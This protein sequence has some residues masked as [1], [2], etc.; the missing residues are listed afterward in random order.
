MQA[1]YSEKFG[2]TVYV[3][4]FKFRL[5]V[6]RLLRL[7]RSCCIALTVIYIG[8]A[9]GGLQ[10]MSTRLFSVSQFKQGLFYQELCSNAS[11]AAGPVSILKRETEMWPCWRN[12]RHWFHW[13]LLNKQ[14]PMK[15]VTALSQIGDIFVSNYIAPELDHQCAWKCTD[16]VHTANLSM[17]SSFPDSTAINDTVVFGCQMVSFKIFDEISR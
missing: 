16:T 15:P 14:L 1:I 5:L 9:F 2:G 17:F 13:M 7:L 3:S 8:W 11:M 12:F 10:L 6:L 4:N